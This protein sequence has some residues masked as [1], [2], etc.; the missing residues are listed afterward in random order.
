MDWLGPALSVGA[1]VVTS[2][3]L[4]GTAYGSL[5]ARVDGLGAKIREE[6]EGQAAALR[7][8]REEAAERLR[9]DA[10]RELRT[11]TT[12]RSDLEKLRTDLEVIRQ[13]NGSPRVLSD[14]GDLKR[15]EDD[16]DK[17]AAQWVPVITEMRAQ[18]LALEKEMD[19]VRLAV[20]EVERQATEELRRLG[21]KGE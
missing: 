17:R 20:R 14:I 7:E 2:A 21:Y 12:L 9:E 8:K 19:K 15:R 18:V 13:R 1:S 10:A 4:I 16:A 11:L 5:R 6:R 3:A